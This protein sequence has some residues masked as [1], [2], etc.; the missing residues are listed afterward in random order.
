[1]SRTNTSSRSFVS[2]GT[3]F[4]AS[5]ENAT[6]RPFPLTDGCVLSPF[7]SLGP[8]DVLARKVTVQP[9]ATTE[10]AIAKSAMRRAGECPMTTILVDSATPD[11][12]PAIP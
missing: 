12:E 2:P 7:T 8:V 9:A 4:D 3:R 1:M 6:Y 10:I 11:A 5:D